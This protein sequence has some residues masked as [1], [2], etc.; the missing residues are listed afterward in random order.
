M[1]FELS[2]DPIF[3]DEKYQPFQLGFHIDK[4]TE[5]K[6]PNLEE[7]A[8]VMFSVSEYRGTSIESKNTDYN[9]FREELYSL[10]KHNFNINLCDLGHLKLGHKK[11]DTYQIFQDVISECFNRNLLPIVIGGG[12]ELTYSMYLAYNN[13]N[14]YVS[15]LSIDNNFD[16]GAGDS[17][18]NS[19]KFM[20][21]IL[22]HTPNKLFNYSNIG[23]QKHFVSYESVKMFNEMHFDVIRLG[24]SRSNI[25][26][27]EPTI[28]AADFVSFDIS[29][30][31]FSDSPGSIKP[32]VNGFF[33][34]EA[35]ALLRYCGIND[36]LSSLGIF[37]FAPQNDIHNQTSKLLSQMIWYFLDGFYNRVDDFKNFD[38]NYKK[39]SV[40]I[41]D[42]QHDTNDTE[43]VFYK[44]LKSG[45]WW[46]KVPIIN[47]DFNFSQDH[48]FIPCSEQDYNIAI[49][50]DLPNRWIIA[51]ERLN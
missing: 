15:L 45:K 39:I 19:D 22:S 20:R 27:L 25:R 13:Q 42:D 49:K 30:I 8:I 24:D 28:R 31:R 3:V 40:F 34:N 36:K 18:V 7:A 46:M 33:G 51:F 43:T 48:C 9:V 6:F 41:R 14:K 11:E 16:L 12:Q 32:T 38:K 29:S 37:N 23:Y 17:T 10:S 2:F 47:N 44:S 35:C 5:G 4:Y 50:G 1:E 21:D 26:E